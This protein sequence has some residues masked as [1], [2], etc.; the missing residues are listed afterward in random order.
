MPKTSNINAFCYTYRY[1]QAGGYPVVNPE[2]GRFPEKMKP[3]GVYHNTTFNPEDGDHNIR[4]TSPTP[5]SWFMFVYTTAA[6]A[7]QYDNFAQKVREEETSFL[8]NMIWVTSETLKS[9]QR[10]QN[11]SI[12]FCFL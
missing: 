11:E 6:A 8:L 1:L 12:T 9:W 2:G 5:G 10:V 3:M 4:I 7:S